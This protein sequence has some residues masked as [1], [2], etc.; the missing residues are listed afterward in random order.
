M[1]LVAT[2][3]SISTPKSNAAAGRRC[4]EE[5]LRERKRHEVQ[6]DV[7][8]GVAEDNGLELAAVNPS[9]CCLM[10]PAALPIGV[11]VTIDM[12]FWGISKAQ[13]VRIVAH[14]HSEILCE[15]DLN[16]SEYQ[17]GAFR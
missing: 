13:F 8:N 2:V 17:N 14:Q 9:N 12:K 16:V 10:V 1:E 7:S 6:T 3:Y 4:G 11:P 5:A 15:K